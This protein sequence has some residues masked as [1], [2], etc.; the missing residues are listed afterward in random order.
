MK[1]VRHDRHARTQFIR[2]FSD[3]SSHLVTT[4]I[5]VHGAW[6]GAWCWDK[7]SP[8]LAAAG[9][10]SV[11]VDLPGHDRNTS[12]FR[13]I[14]LDDYVN[15]VS[16]LLADLTEPVVLV[17]HSHGG[18]TISMAAERQPEMI[19]TLVYVCAFLLHDGQSIAD[20]VAAGEQSIVKRNMV[21]TDVGHRIMIREEACREGLFNDC[22]DAEYKWALSQL[23]PEPSSPRTTP[24]KLTEERF[25]RVRRTYIECLKDNAIPISVQRKMCAT[26]P[27][28]RVIRMNTSHSPFISSPQELASHL[29]AI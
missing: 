28:E 23:V 15:S 25:G 16:Q 21:S 27:C 17:G 6:H 7:V 2:R 5:L 8:L 1:S 12:T 24:V 14:T 18:A 19:S 20:V 26:L 29:L 9:H 3:S 4:Y 10:T 22:S 11:A 13:D